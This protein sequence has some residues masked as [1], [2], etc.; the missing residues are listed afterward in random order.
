MAEEKFKAT[1]GK[2][3]FQGQGDFLDF[4]SHFFFLFLLLPEIIYFFKS[5]R[6]R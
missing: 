5:Y 4:L 1:F 2:L 6:D 3:S